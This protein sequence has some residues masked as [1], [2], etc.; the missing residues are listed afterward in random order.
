MCVSEGASARGVLYWQRLGG[1]SLKGVGATL[2]HALTDGVDLT[3][4]PNLEEFGACRDGR[5][6][7]SL[8]SR[9]DSPRARSS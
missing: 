3:Y 9:L 2:V 7:A 8:G 1:P 4:K 5:L 6:E